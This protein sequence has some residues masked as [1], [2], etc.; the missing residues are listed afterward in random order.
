M[1][2]LVI[3]KASRALLVPQPPDVDWEGGTNDADFY[4]QKL[5]TMIW[6]INRDHVIRLIQTDTENWKF[7]RPFRDMIVEMLKLQV[8][9]DHPEKQTPEFQLSLPHIRDTLTKWS[10]EYDSVREEYNK[11]SYSDYTTQIL[12]LEYRLEKITPNWFPEIARILM[13]HYETTELW[14]L[15]DLRSL[16]YITETL[17]DWEGLKQDGGLIMSVFKQ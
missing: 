4:N 13:Y 12:E 3:D 9:Y 15:K 10:G 7:Q 16:K 5:N 11:T 14:I 1:L 17:P 2:Y 8:K 6:R